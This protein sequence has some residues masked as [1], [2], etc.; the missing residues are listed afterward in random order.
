M[1]R[2]YRGI[3]GLSLCV[4]SVMPA[5]MYAESEPSQFERDVIQVLL[6][7]PEVV[8]MALEKLRSAEEDE[9]LKEEATR[10]QKNAMPLFEPDKTTG[11]EP[12]VVEFFDYLCGFCANAAV[13][14][15]KVS[16]A[17]EGKIRLV[18]YP[19]LGEVSEGLSALALG[20]KHIYGLKTYE[21]FHYRLMSAMRGKRS[22]YGAVGIMED[23]GLDKDLVLEFAASDAVKNEIAENRRIGRALG[24]NGTPAFLTKDK[25]HGGI[26]DE[27]ALVAII[28]DEH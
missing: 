8:L 15:A 18:E 10:I 28:N 22:E 23:M 12:V 13:H 5:Q 25:L 16:A 27:A 14:M 11:V 1:N 24:V 2:F 4:C 17:H 26:L 21:K 3:A 20:V 7:H 6:D 19:I 9:K